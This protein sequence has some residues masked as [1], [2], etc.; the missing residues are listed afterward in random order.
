M[1]LRLTTRVAALTVGSALLLTACGGGGGVNLPTL[2]PTRTATASPTVAL[3]TASL[4]TPT[5]PAPTLTLPEPTLT[6]PTPTLPTLSTSPEPTPTITDG[7][8]PTTTAG[9][10]PTTT[11][12]TP[13]ATTTTQPTTTSTTATPTTTTTPPTTTT[14]TET[15]STTT[16][17]PEPT[18]TVGTEPTTAEA[19]GT[20]AWVWW[21]IAAILI[22]LAIAIPLLLRRRRLEQWLAGFDTTRAAVA[23]FAR[24]LI[25][26][27]RQTGS[28]EAAGAAWGVSS[29]RA[30]A[31]EDQLGSMSVTAPD[32]RTRQ[33]ALTLR[34]AVRGAIRQVDALVASGADDSRLQQLD[35]V[36][37]ELETALDATS[38]HPTSG[39]TS[40]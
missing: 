12:T 18:G 4:P 9:P 38:P 40:I 27:L 6:V 31:A 22:A 28:R 29:E 8:S 37:A 36:A 17:T 2:S 14:T 7:P 24:A 39:Q 16:T 3:P 19:A 25:P 13:A 20:P 23:W 33:R 26:A 15:P 5:P 1:T 10:S 11:P 35:A 32:D 21:L 30:I 34:D